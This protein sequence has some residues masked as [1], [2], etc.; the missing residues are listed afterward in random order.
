MADRVNRRDEIVTR[1]AELFIEHGY[2][3]T[4]VR[5]IAEAVGVTEAALYYHFPEGKRALLQAVV[6]SHTPDLNLALDDCR[7]AND[8]HDFVLCFGQALQATS[9]EGQLERFR[10]IISE[11]HRF[12]D[13]EKSLF[14]EKYMRA[15]NDLHAALGRHVA[16]ADLAHDVAWIVLSAAFGYAHLFRTLE[17]DR[18]ADFHIDRL[19]QLIA[20]ALGGRFSPSAA[21]S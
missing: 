1:A 11:F 14:H 3:G 15:F 4:S 18:V 17:I 19:L 13:D 2:T 10:W 21:N 6:E 7:S 8:L 9:G 16:D 20:A 12:S 5:Q